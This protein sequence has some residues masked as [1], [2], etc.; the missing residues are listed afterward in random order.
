MTTITE[1]G[2]TES[3]KRGA[4]WYYVITT[5]DPT[6]G[7]RKTVMKSAGQGCDQGGR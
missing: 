5:F 4:V 7:K 1:D 6:T 2:Q 3:L